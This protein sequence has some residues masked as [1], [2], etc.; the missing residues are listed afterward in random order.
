MCDGLDIFEFEHL[1]YEQK[2]LL[3]TAGPQVHDDISNH[4]F[5]DVSKQKITR[6]NKVF[7]SR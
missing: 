3:C 1:K 7:E 4:D 2:K 5:F 6:K